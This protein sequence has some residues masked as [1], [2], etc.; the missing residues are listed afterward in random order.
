MRVPLAVSPTG[1]WR[2]GRM[3]EPVRIAAWFLPGSSNGYEPLYSKGSPGAVDG[4]LPMPIGLIA[5][6]RT[7]IGVFAVAHGGCHC[8]RK[9]SNL[10]E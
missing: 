9:R 3:D 8:E 7:V 5:M 6:T 4:R 1:L 10:D 2:P